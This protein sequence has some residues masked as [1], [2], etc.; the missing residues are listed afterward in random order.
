MT[1]IAKLIAL[2]FGIGVCVGCGEGNQDTSGQPTAPDF[3]IHNAKIV[4]VDET[5]SFAE[6]AA[7]KESRFVAVGTDTEVL[8]SAGPETRRVDLEGISREEAIRAITY[9]AAYTSF[10]QDKKG[11]VEVGKYADFVVLAEDILT[12]PDEDIKDIEVVATVLAGEPVYGS[13]PQ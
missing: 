9:T 11:S 6:A 3:I 4:T 10:E 12:V 1:R 7:I 13:L 5:F 2:A 8:A